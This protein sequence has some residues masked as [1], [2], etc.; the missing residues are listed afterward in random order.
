MYQLIEQVRRLQTEL[1]QI[2][3]LA[4][5]ESKTITVTGRP[6]EVVQAACD[7]LDIPGCEVIC[8]SGGEV[9]IIFHP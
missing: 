8:R 3:R 9:E 1:E 7:A 5:G 6:Q 4:E 2:V